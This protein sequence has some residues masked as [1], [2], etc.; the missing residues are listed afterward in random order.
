MLGRLAQAAVASKGAARA[1]A[2]AGRHRAAAREREAAAEQLQYALAQMEVRE[3]PFRVFVVTHMFLL[4]SSSTEPRRRNARAHASMGIQGGRHGP[5]EVQ[6]C[7]DH[8]EVFFA[9][10]GRSVARAD[11]D[12]CAWEHLCE[13]SKPD[14][15]PRM[16]VHA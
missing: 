9:L 3:W 8:K 1:A 15:T 12:G 16:H 10:G 2:D 5:V 4:V 6:H 7:T 14:F 13:H 11:A